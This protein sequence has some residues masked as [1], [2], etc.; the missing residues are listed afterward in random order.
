MSPK[1]ENP[2]FVTIYAQNVE[3][4][5]ETTDNIEEANQQLRDLGREM[6][7]QLFLSTE[8]ADKTK[9]TIQ[10]REDVGKLIE[11]TFR[12]LFD[13]RPT[14][15]D[16]ES[17]RGSVK[18]SDKDCIFC[19]EVSLEGMRGFGYCEVFSGILEAL[20]EYKGVQSKVFQEA[21]KA[22]GGDKCV[23]NVRLE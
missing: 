15:I 7:Q 1:I 17:A 23:W 18:V 22:T 19:Q 8:I 10:T 14:E 5:L 16:M 12:I 3:K 9:E 4:I 11:T 6:G 20:L 2:L 13:K 21:S